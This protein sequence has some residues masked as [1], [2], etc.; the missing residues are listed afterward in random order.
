MPG[1]PTLLRVSPAM[2]MMCFGDLIGAHSFIPKV[3]N[4]QLRNAE[5]SFQ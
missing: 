2:G 3:I 5:I 4:N 1:V